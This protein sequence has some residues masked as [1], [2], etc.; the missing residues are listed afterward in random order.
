MKKLLLTL[1]FIIISNQ[2][3]ADEDFYDT[4]HN[5]ATCSADIELSSRLILLGGYYGEAQSQVLKEKANGWLIASVVLFMLDGMGSEGAWSSAQGVKDTT[6][7]NWAAKLEFVTNSSL[8]EK[9]QKSNFTKII[10][11]LEILIP[12]CL[13]YENLVEESIKTYRK[14]AY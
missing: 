14:M 10:D 5:L 11:E 13:L 9:E 7:S 12:D 8:S 2:S 4:A 1:L 3:I 6:L